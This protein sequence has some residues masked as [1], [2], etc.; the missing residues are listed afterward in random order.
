[1]QSYWMYFKGSSNSCCQTMWWYPTMFW[2]LYLI[3]IKSY[4]RDFEINY[5]FLSTYTIFFWHFF[6]AGLLDMINRRLIY[7]I[8]NILLLYYIN[9]HSKD[10]S[11]SIPHSAQS[12][13]PIPTTSN[14]THLVSPSPILTVIYQHLAPLTVLPSL[15][16]F[17]SWCRSTKVWLD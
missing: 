5:I 12:T 13:T 3:C 15:K 16:V 7:L 10:I 8:S 14:S 6:V 1:M 11:C 17:L 2:Y 4:K 9:S